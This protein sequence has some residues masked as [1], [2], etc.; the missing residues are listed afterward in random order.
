[1]SGAIMNKVWDLFRMAAE[2]KMMK[3]QKI[4]MKY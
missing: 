2:A 4:M 3:K 1:M